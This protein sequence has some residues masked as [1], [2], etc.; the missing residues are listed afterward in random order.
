MATGDDL[1]LRTVRIVRTSALAILSAAMQLFAKQFLPWLTA[2]VGSVWY[3][4]VP[5]GVLP[6]WAVATL[7][8]LAIFGALWAFWRLVFGPSRTWRDYRQDT[9]FGLLCRWRY[10]LAGPIR[11][12]SLHCPT[13]K[14]ELSWRIDQEKRRPCLTCENCSRVVNDQLRQRENVPAKVKRQIRAR[15]RTGEWKNAVQRKGA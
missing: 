8:F 6:E 10:S 1:A 3:F 12:L 7:G 14:A 4:F 15:I 2:R 13:C 5:K 11:G 9:F